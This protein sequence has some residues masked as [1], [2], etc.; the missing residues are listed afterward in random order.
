MLS[1]TLRR[2]KQ[3]HAGDLSLWGMLLLEF[4]TIVLAVIVGFAVNEWRDG[5]RRDDAAAAALEGI[6]RELGYNHRQLVDTLLYYRAV[7]G[8]IDARLPDPEAPEG[9][10]TYGYQLPGWRGAMPPLLRSSS[11]DMALAT[12]VIAD[13][14]FDQAHALAQIY[15]FQQVLEKL[16]ENML[17]RA[18]NDP[19]FTRI[20]T[21][22]H[23]FGLYAE[24][25]PSL[26]AMYELWAAPVLLDHPL[27][28][29][30]ADPEL[31]ARVERVRG[32]LVSSNTAGNH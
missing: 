10:T 25:G 21:V 30:I 13:L 18:A 26:L 16:D 19:G 4:T 23:A 28:T 22:R 9:T 6:S 7:L 17:A 14:P 15:N 29:T 32:R 3:I 8:E 20:A 11:F 5:Q 12:G 27:D 24:L 2:L 1:R 31:Q